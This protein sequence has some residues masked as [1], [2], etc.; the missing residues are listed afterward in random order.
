MAMSC[1]P[2]AMVPAVPRIRGE[3]CWMAGPDHDG[4]LPRGGCR[5]P[6]ARRTHSGISCVHSLRATAAT[7]W[8]REMVGHFQLMNPKMRLRESVETRYQFLVN[9]LSFIHKL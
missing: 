5:A 7:K 8:I 6:S 2:L 3:L 9:F 4:W 1:A